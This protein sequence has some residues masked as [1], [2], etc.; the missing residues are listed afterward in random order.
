MQVSRFHVGLS[1]F[2]L[3]E[4]RELRERWT[5]ATGVVTT[6]KSYPPHH[7]PKKAE[8]T[9]YDLSLPI[10]CFHSSDETATLVYKTT[11]KISNK[12]C[13][14]IELNSQK[15]FSLLFFISTWPPLRHV[16]TLHC[17]FG[18]GLGETRK[19]SKYSF[20]MNRNWDLPITSS[21]RSFAPS[22]KF[23]DQCLSLVG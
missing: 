7:L 22:C 8:A 3:S 9:V 17:Y 1:N 13:I 5:Q 2:F 15:T 14:K 12:F 11:A 10:E 6:A 18:C 19:K 4:E 21:S 16:K 23:W 20:T